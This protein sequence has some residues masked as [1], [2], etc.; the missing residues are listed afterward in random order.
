MRNFAGEGQ[1]NQSSALSARP[2]DED[3]KV[4]AVQRHAVNASLLNHIADHSRTKT[5]SGG[6]IKSLR[7]IFPA[8]CGEK[9][10]RDAERVNAF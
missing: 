8:A 9:I 5:I 4:Q 1:P 2:L 10:F 7:V 3:K 6:C